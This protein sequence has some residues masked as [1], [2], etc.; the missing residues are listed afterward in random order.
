MGQDEVSTLGALTSH[1]KDFIDPAIARYRGRLVKSTGDGFLLE[2]GSVV[3]ATCFAITVQQGMAARNE[4]VPKSRQIRFRTG[5]N[6]GDIIFQD[7]DIFGHGVNVAARLETLAE[8][9]GICLSRA[10]HDQVRDK[11]DAPFS[12][13]GSHMVKN[14]TDPVEVFGLS[15]EAIAAIA[16]ASIEAPLQRPPSRLRSLYFAGAV[17]VVA[18]FAGLFYVLA[19]RNPEKRLGEDLGT[20]L[21]AILPNSSAKARERLLAD[22]TGAGKHRAFV[23]APK[24]RAHWWSGDWPS[25]ELAQEKVLERCQAAFDEPC[26][27]VAADDAVIASD[28]K[29]AWLPRDMPRARYSGPFDPE[30]IPGLR[31]ST[32]QR[33]D[34]LGYAAAPSPKAIAYHP[35]GLVFVVTSASSQHI[36]ELQALRNCNDSS[37]RRE[38]DGSCYLYAVENRVVFVER[39]SA[40]ATSR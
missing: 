28:A 30:R 13:I 39:H 4:D 10:A 6:I 1:R 5:V 31:A 34:V 2:F 37:S 8:P 18:A 20:L 15:A 19:A 12:D 11:I 24:A 40:P 32:A 9:G 7:G 29:G 23:I 33:P 14:I 3:D 22:Y 26:A 36:A 38:A 27:V 21:S 35:R 17:L 25:L 16:P